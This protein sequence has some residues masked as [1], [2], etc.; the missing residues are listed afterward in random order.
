MTKTYKVELVI[1][2]HDGK[3]VSSYIN[4]IAEET[5]VTAPESELIR[6]HIKLDSVA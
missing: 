6:K 5:A 2:T 3:V 4:S 1:N